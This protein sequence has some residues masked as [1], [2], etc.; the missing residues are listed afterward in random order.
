MPRELAVKIAQERDLL[1]EELQRL[2]HAHKEHQI[3]QQRRETQWRED[4]NALLMQTRQQQRKIEALEGELERTMEERDAAEYTSKLLTSLQ[5]TP[6]QASAPEGGEEEPPIEEV[7]S[8]VL[9]A[10]PEEAPQEERAQQDEALILSMLTLRDSLERA[11]SMTT[12]P[13]NPWKQGLDHMIAQFDETLAEHGWESVAYNG[14]EFNPEVHEAVGTV[15]TEDR[16]R[17]NQI[18]EVV[19]QGFANAQQSRLA[20]PAQVVVLRAPSEST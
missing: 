19:R 12:D 10:T 13:D 8:E 1:Y 16:A 14:E 2:Q 4:H 3:A 7:Y 18:Q 20:R 17:H 5:D 15:Q 6:A 9:E 11:S